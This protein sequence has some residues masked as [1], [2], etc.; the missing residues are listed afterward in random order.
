VQSAAS[1]SGQTMTRALGGLYVSGAALALVWT[2]LPHGPDGG[3][4]V[5]L[6]MATLTIGLGVPLV[7]GVVSQLRTGYLHA[8]IAVIQIVIAIGYVAEADPSG[9]IRLF[10]VWATPYAA[11]YFSGR[12]AAAHMAWTAAVL[13]ASL[14][15]MPG[16]THGRAPAVFALTM[17]TVCASGILVAWAARA[18][19]AAEVVQRYQAAHDP[20]TGLPNRTLFA[21]EARAAL[22]VQDGGG[23]RVAVALID[24]DRFKLVNDTYGHETGD[25]LLKVV[26]ERLRQ[27]LPE[28]DLVARL[29]GDEFA[30][31]LRSVTSP[32]EVEPAL[33]RL[34]SV[35]QEPVRIN[36]VSVY[37]TGSAGVVLSCR[38]RTTDESLLSDADA[39]MYHAKSTR[40]GSWEVFDE[41][42]R[43]RVA[44]RLQIEACLHEPAVRDQMRVVFQ[45]II[46][47]STGQVRSAEALLRWT[48]PHL[49]V[50]APSDFIPVAEEIG[51][52]VGIGEWVL[53]QGIRQVSLWRALDVVGDDFRLTVNVSGVQIDPG[54]PRLV[55]QVLLD[56]GVPG[57]VLGL[58]IT[59]TALLADAD[60]VGPALATL[61]AIGVQILLDDFG[62]GYSSLS[63]LHQFP[64]DAI[65]VDRTFIAE[66]PAACPG[67]VDAIVSLGSVLGLAV[68]AEGVETE[69]QAAALR[70]IGCGL[71]QGY[72]FGRPVPAGE[73]ARLVRERSNTTVS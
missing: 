50:V 7:T 34:D 63:H 21:E 56:G 3:D 9:D 67:I 53:R 4:R 8:A 55:E 43:E 11:L 61:R 73:F 29:G 22:A 6:A 35:W 38:E 42:M 60:V 30:L 65:K 48:H 58:E 59:E 19:R 37:T 24:L 52:I 1:L 62:T 51:M 57:S 18:L 49:G 71:A 44:R 66:L 5:V 45:P 54:F 27:H 39:A 31:L 10:F 16:G 33:A 14:A 12:A 17:G 32:E 36:E 64:L 23:P 46:D 25:A 15:L 28:G 13:A 68:V 41:A 40:P 20:L 69:E 72:L 47:L 2:R 26:A 70:S